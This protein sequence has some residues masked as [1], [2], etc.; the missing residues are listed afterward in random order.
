M[1]LGTWIGIGLFA[2]A[3]VGCGGGGGGG[4]SYNDVKN[5]FA[6]PTG[7]LAATNADAVAKA[8]ET[9]Q[10]G[11][12]LALG[13]R[14]DV[15]TS[16]Q[17]VSQSI[18]CPSGGTYSI[19]TEVTGTSSGVSTIT[20]NNCC[21]AAACCYNG[22]GTYYTSISGTSVGSICGT[23]QLTLTCGAAP[24][25]A[26]ASFCEDASNGTFSYLVQVDGKSFAVSG[27]YSSGSGTLTITGV[28]GT[29]TCTYTNDT[30]TCTGTAGSFS[31]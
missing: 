4:G 8:Y 11:G 7:T 31:F 12:G 23:E 15:T 13:R 22:G 9:S 24:A 25:T 10:A 18:S 14:L 16:A 2:M 29:F 5:S 27:N 3:G 26:S 17:T 19:S 28:N 1:R 6:H 21:Y 30:G 20:W